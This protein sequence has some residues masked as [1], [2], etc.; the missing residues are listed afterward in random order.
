MISLEGCIGSGKSTTANILGDR[1]GWS[2]LLGL[3]LSSMFLEQFYVSPNRMALETELGFLLVHYHQLRTLP[4]AADIISDFAPGRDVVFARLNLSGDDLR[5]F[6]N[7]YE[8]LISRVKQPKL[9]VFLRV[10][11]NELLR[12]IQERGRLYELQMTVEYLESLNQLYDANT[13][14][15]GP[16]VKI[17]D[18]RPGESPIEV[19]EKVH[20]VILDAGY[21]K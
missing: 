12:R 16:N 19:A 13:S 18:V 4:P 8:H 20:K 17:V 21:L 5:V 1:L 2:T 3:P 9:T 10:P 14:L 7:L 15:L 6:E 11:V